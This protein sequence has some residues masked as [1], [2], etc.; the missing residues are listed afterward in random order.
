MFLPQGCLIRI[1]L[2]EHGYR[3]PVDDS[4]LT[5]KRYTFSIIQKWVI[6][7]FSPVSEKT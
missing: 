6:N 5:V 7:D 3:S 2:K 1:L 4:T